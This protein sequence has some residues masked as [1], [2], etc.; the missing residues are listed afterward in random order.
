MTKRAT[1]QQLQQKCDNF[2]EAC[3]IGT[4]V[5]YES[6][7]GDPMTR[8]ETKTRSEA[9]VLSGHTA[10]VFVEDVAGCVALDHVEEIIRSAPR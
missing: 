10:V 4:T 6:V 1:P 7:K 5:I 2:N 8:R 9:Y 3:P